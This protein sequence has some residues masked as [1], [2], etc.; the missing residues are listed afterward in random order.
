LIARYNNGEELELTYELS[1]LSQQTMR[2]M[3]N[4]SPASWIDDDI[5]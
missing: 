3:S 5:A 2:A 4:S 1:R